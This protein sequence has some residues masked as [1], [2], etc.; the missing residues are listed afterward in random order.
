M[1]NTHEPH[2]ARKTGGKTLSLQVHILKE[3]VPSCPEAR[4]ELG[5]RVRR[6]DSPSKSSSHQD[7]QRSIHVKGFTGGG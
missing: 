7:E 3:Q 6:L 4:S 5:R 1:L 2:T